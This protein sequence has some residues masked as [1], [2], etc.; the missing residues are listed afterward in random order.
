MVRHAI[1][2]FVDLAIVVALLLYVP[3]V[4]PTYVLDLIA[5]TFKDLIYVA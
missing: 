2:S 4:F 5:A 1:H 3:S